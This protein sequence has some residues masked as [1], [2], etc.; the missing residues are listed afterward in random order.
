MPSRPLKLLHPATTRLVLPLLAWKLLFFVLLFSSLRL[1]PDFFNLRSYVNNYAANHGAPPLDMPSLATRFQ[2]WDAAHY[3]WIA[4]HGYAL[5]GPWASFYPLWPGLI[6]AGAPLLGGSHLLAGLVLANLFSLLALLL[7]HDLL[8]RRYGSCEADLGLA[9]MLAYPGTLFLCFP[10]S[11]ALFLLLSVAVFALLQRERLGGAALLAG[12]LPLTRAVGLFA[13]APLLVALWRRG[14]LKRRGWLA[15]T[16]LAGFGVYL[17]VMALATG[18]PLA[19]FKSQ[20]GFLARSS[21]GDMFSPLQFLSQLF[22]PLELHGYLD[23][24]ID[25]L[26]FAWFLLG[27][28][29]L[30]LRARREAEWL[31]YALPL[32]LV[33]AM[34]VKFMAY[35]RYLVVVFPIFA[36]SAVWL[37]RRDKGA[38]AWA[39][40]PALGFLQLLLLL[41]HFNHYWAG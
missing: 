18:D 22:T 25:R 1:L 37:V 9:L 27:L 30:A 39:L 14:Q 20:Q 24:G 15:L 34:T 3:L 13:M 35:T 28:V 5:E 4:E 10:F 16:P 11:E 32:G 29:L 21:I 40:V 12:L 2:T 36:I 26:M 38:W 33:P 23:S 8:V 6:R 31:V 17:A 41:R 7:L 19:G